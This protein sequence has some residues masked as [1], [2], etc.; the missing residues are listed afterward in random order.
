MLRLRIPQILTANEALDIQAKSDDD[1][2]MGMMM[3]AA[4]KM[5]DAVKGGTASIQWEAVYKIFEKVPREKLADHIAETVLQTKTYVS[6]AV[7][8]KYLNNESR[9]NFVKS[10][11]VNLM[12]TPEYQVG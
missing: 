6:R 9:E 10:V 5:K 7:L 4:K 3:E 12:S 1:Q 11:M 8:D 2:Q